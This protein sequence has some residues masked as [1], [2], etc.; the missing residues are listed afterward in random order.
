MC[1]GIVRGALRECLGSFPPFLVL[2]A[3]PPCPLGGG[4]APSTPIAHPR[5][6]WVRQ[7]FGSHS[8]AGLLM[9]QLAPLLMFCEGTPPTTPHQGAPPPG[10]PVCPPPWTLGSPA[11]WVPLGAGWLM[12]QLTP[13]FEFVGGHP[14]RPPPGGEAPWP[15]SFA[16]PRRLWVCQRHVAC[17]IASG[18]SPDDGQWRVSR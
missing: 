16:R 9:W 3:H 8:W 10:P 15:P 12:W 11:F 5:G 14:W 1:S 18:K 17:L 13:S 7:R 6:L 4:A 2:G